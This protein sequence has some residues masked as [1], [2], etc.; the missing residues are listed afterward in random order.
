MTNILFDEG[1]TVP[2]GET[3]GWILLEGESNND[4]ARQFDHGIM[5][6]ET[7][8]AEQ[9]GA[10]LPFEASAPVS[11]ASRPV[12]SP[13]A[14]R[15]ARQQGIDLAT[16]I[17]TGPNG[18]ITKVDVLQ[19]VQLQATADHGHDSDTIEPLSSMRQ[20]IVRHVM[21][22]AALPQIVLYSHAD[23]SALLELR[24]HDKAI[25]FDDMIARC[26]AQ[27]IVDHRYFNA[28]F[29]DNAIRLHEKTNIGLAVNVEQGLV[30]PVLRD[31]ATVSV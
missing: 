6:A 16:I 20:A 8:A 1:S 29:C 21:R 7:S 18:R 31:A 5:Q 27:T 19:V 28:S 30:I 12:A 4:I 3:I 22:S 10:T 14:R 15:E 9:S 2:V 26:A 25:A 23:A 11:T 17:G 24:L 13:A